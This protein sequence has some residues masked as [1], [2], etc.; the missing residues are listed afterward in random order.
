[1]AQPQIVPT[2]NP[3]S[4]YVIVKRGLNGYALVLLALAVFGMVIGLVLFLLG[5]NLGSNPQSLGD[6]GTSIQL[7][8]A[9][10]VVAG[11]GLLAL[12][13]WLTAQAIRH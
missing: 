7:S 9:G 6:I 3:A 10:G 1:M 12:L 2:G 11:I 8:V 4:P 13:L 5:Q